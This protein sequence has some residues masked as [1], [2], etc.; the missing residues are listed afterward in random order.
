MS[1]FTD[2]VIKTEPMFFRATY[3]YALKKGGPITKE[4]LSK[5]PEDFVENSKRNNFLLD[6]RCTWRCLVCS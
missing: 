6:S 2:E 1:K 4:F 5:L 3:D